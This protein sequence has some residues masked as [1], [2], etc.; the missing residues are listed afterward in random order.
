MVILPPVRRSVGLDF[1]SLADRVSTAPYSDNPVDGDT[2]PLAELFRVPPEVLQQIIAAEH[3]GLPIINMIRLLPDAQRWSRDPLACVGPD[4]PE[5]TPTESVFTVSAHALLGDYCDTE[6]GA[7]DHAAAA[8]AYLADPLNLEIQVWEQIRDT[9][10]GLPHNP[11]VADGCVRQLGPDNLTPWWT[12]TPQCDFDPWEF[13]RIEY[14][15]IVVPP[16]MLP[17]G[18]IGFDLIQ[19]WFADVVSSVVFVS[20]ANL[21]RWQVE[22]RFVAVFADPQ[23]TAP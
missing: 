9:I 16:S 3:A 8:A 4:K 23:H 15:P 21:W 7:N 20:R 11:P 14:A 17:Q 18:D 6:Q 5:R 22:R 12:A 1:R 13:T 10:Y 2:S 19:V